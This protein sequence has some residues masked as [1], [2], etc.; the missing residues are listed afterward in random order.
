MLTVIRYLYF[1]KKALNL[2][3]Y[4]SDRYVNVTGCFADSDFA[5]KTYDQQTKY[6]ALL[7][8]SALYKIVKIRR[9]TL[10]DVK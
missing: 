10:T 5:H 4:L 9:S 2:F 7:N 8:Y 1:F 6:D 3:D